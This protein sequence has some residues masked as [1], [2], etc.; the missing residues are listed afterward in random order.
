MT[1]RFNKIYSK[2]LA[3]KGKQNFIELMESIIHKLEPVKNAL[4]VK[5]KKYARRDYIMDIIEVFHN[6]TSWRKYNGMIDGR[7]LNNKHNYYSKLGVYEELYKINLKR[8]LGK[9]KN[10]LNILL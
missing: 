5:H 10:S 9:T 3:K 6:N 2:I 1:E 8:Y 4:Y 7:V